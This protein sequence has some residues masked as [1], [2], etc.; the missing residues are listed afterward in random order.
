MD[1]LMTLHSD[2]H[3]AAMEYHKAMKAC[4]EAVHQ[5]DY[6]KQQ[7]SAEG[8]IVAAATYK[9]TLEQ[10]LPRLPQGAF[11]KDSQEAREHYTKLIE[12][13]NS[14]TRQMLWLLQKFSGQ[15]LK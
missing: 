10:L 9:K 13:L 7:Q 14:E 3:A 11:N 2:M 6:R 15:E 1:E 4:L 12:F 8:L 5:S